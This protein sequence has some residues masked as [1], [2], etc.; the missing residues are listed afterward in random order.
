MMKRIAARG[1]QANLYSKK[2]KKK[3]FLSLSLL[4][5]PENLLEKA[6]YGENDCQY[7]YN[8]VYLW[9]IIYYTIGVFL[10]NIFYYSVHK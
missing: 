3:L 4:R 10:E 2:K 1:T 7:S 9:L 5:E 8:E 6:K